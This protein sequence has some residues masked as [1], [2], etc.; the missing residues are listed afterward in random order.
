MALL[1]GRVHDGLPLTHPGSH[2]YT[3]TH[4]HAHARSWPRLLLLEGPLRRR[5][6]SPPHS[7][8][9]VECGELIDLIDMLLLW[10]NTT[11]PSQARHSIIQYIISLQLCAALFVHFRVANRVTC[12]DVEHPPAFHCWTACDSLYNCYFCLTSLNRH[13]RFGF[14]HVGYKLESG[15]YLPC[16][17]NQTWHA[18]RHAS[19]VRVRGKAGD[20]TEVFLSPVSPA[21]SFPERRREES[22]VR[23]RAAVY[24]KGRAFGDLASP[25]RAAGLTVYP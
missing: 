17:S 2:T 24:S 14:E 9:P 11:L 13:A 6:V 8:A 19:M 16:L 25:E 1:S 22:S 20:G 21:A 3:R 23:S 10:W 18:S 4:I 12:S 7:H 15:L 5:S